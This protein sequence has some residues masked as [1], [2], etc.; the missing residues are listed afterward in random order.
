MPSKNIYTDLAIEAK[1]L[2]DEGCEEAVEIPGVSMES[3]K[4]ED[5]IITVTWVKVLNES[6][7]REMG[8]PI[9]SYVTIEAPAIKDNS[10]LIAEEVA[11]IVAEQLKRLI[12]LPEDATVLVAGLG[13]WN[14]TPDALGPKVVSKILVT[15]HILEEVPDEIDESVRPVSALAPGVMGIT[16]I[17]TQEIIRGVVDRVKPDLLIAVDALAA[18]KTS[19][20]NSTIQMSDTGVA[21]GGGMGNKR[22]SLNRETLGVPVI[23][24][25]VPTVVD[26][27]TL[28]NDTLDLMLGEMSA[29]AE[30]G[31]EF[32]DMLKDLESEEKY[33]LIVELLDPYAENMFVTPKEVDA[34][35]ERLAKIISNGMNI[36]LHPGID[37]NDINRYS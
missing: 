2:L 15:R 36:A 34:V 37:I 16:G 27:A 7:A 22:K 20:I 23:A 24:I 11:G 31:S 14:V 3:Y 33:R 18:R 1:E 19:R 30:E 13:N 28:I 32:Y 8:K 9:G 25:G 26:A 4:N 10:A 6:G 17:E 29:A 21:P 5:G 12:D 35:I